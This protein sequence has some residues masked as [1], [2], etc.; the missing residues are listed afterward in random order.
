[1]RII[2]VSPVKVLFTISVSS[3]SLNTSFDSSSSEPDAK[4]YIASSMND[5]HVFAL[6]RKTSL[7]TRITRMLELAV[8]IVVVQPVSAATKAQRCGE[9]V[10]LELKAAR[11]KCCPT[12]SH[13]RF[14]V[15]VGC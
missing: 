15:S 2:G 6:M 7:H 12:T 1:M 5:V 14:E 9:S 13:V 10:R 11:L 3:S 4:L 8:T